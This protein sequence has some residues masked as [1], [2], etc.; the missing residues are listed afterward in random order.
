MARLGSDSVMA[1]QGCGDRD[2]CGVQGWMGCQ[3]A[4]EGQDQAQ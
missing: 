2:G 1:G 3:C 4:G